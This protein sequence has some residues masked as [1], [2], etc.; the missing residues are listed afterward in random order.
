MDLVR[1]A[2]KHHTPPEQTCQKQL[3]ECAQMPDKHSQQRFR[4][5]NTTTKEFV[6]LN[7][8]PFVCDVTSKMFV[9]GCQLTYG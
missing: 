2:D 1:R 5:E 8:L 7:Y 9:G 4:L 3:E 6:C